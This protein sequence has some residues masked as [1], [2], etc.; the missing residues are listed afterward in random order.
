[1]DGAMLRAGLP[2]DGPPEGGSPEGGPPVRRVVVVPFAAAA[3]RERQVAAANAR[4]WYEGLGAG[5][6]EIVLGE[7][8]A[9]AGDLGPADLVVLPG[10]SPHRLLEG[11]M[12]SAQALREAVDRGAAVSGSSAGAMVL[13]RW[14][15]LP[16]G[17]PR[18]VPALGLVPVDLVLPHYREDA[19]G[20]AW[21]GV[22]RGVVPAGGLVLGLPERSGVVV[23]ADG[24]R[25]PVGVS[26]VTELPL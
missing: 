6:V 8:D 1:M 19:G 24:T 26:P 14:T 18:V 5:D 4:R 22:A 15:V 16:G 7:A 12:P 9:F 2:G 21:L 3:G 20:S 10:G 17:A 25:E 11:L 23:R 13:C